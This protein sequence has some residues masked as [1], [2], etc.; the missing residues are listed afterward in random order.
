MRPRRR[1]QRQSRRRS[2]VN[3]RP[4]NVVG[5]VS[6]K[7]YDGTTDDLLTGGLGKTRARRGRR[8]DVREPGDAPRAAELRKSAIYNNYRALRRPDR[9][10]RLRHAVRPERRRERQRHAPAK[11]K[12]AGVE[13]TAYSDDGSGTRERDAARADP[14]D[15]SIRTH[16]CIESAPRRPDRAACTARS[17]RP[18]WGLKHGCA[19]ALTDKGTSPAPHDLQT[20]TVALIDGTRT[21]S[22]L[23][24]NERDVPRRT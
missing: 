8:P 16:P 4:T 19:V 5:A 15:A 11:G 14:V 1:R 18:E 20:D 3:V 13:Y 2:S 10:R 12:I 6:V 7:T 9:R 17:R 23:A 24:G 22:A 21:T